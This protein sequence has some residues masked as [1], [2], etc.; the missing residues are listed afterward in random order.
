MLLFVGEEVLLLRGWLSDGKWQ[1]PGGGLH[2]EENPKAGMIREL[3]EETGLN[4]KPNEIIGL[5]VENYSEKGFSFECHYFMAR[6][7]KK[8]FPGSK[9]MEISGHTWI[10]ASRITQ[11]NTGKDVARALELVSERYRVGLVSQNA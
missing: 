3:Q 2:A 9:G 1:L 4:L 5:A 6:I 7:N 8:E 10:P 11:K